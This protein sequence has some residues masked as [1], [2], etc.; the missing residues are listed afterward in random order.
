MLLG[1]MSM[2]AVVSLP[3]SRPTGT[4]HRHRDHLLPLLY[5]TT[6]ANSRHCTVLGR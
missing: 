6:A 4:F 5:Y 3:T 1:F 2:V